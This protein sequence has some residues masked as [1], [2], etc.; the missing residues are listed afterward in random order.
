MQTITQMM[1]GEALFSEE[2]QTGIS[3]EWNKTKINRMITRI[4]E[5]MMKMNNN[6]MNKMN[7]KNRNDL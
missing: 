3:E 5:I 4:T 1:E 6:K 7:N 2:I